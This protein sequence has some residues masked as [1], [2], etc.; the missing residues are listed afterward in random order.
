MLL[1]KVRS[2]GGY[3]ISLMFDDLLGE[4]CIVFVEPLSGELRY[5]VMF[6]S[7]TYLG[8]LVDRATRS[9]GQ[10][11]IAPVSDVGEEDTL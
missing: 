2:A 3:S 7:R 10:F 11:I 6:F 9:L 4:E 5:M 1:G 8:T